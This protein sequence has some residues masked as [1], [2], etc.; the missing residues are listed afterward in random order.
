MFLGFSL[1]VEGNLMNLNWLAF[2][3]FGINALLLLFAYGLIYIFEKTFGF[4]SNVTLV[5]LSNVNTPL[6]LKFSELA[7]W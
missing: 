6:L 1:V 4:L 7:P 3:Y 5:E 2:L